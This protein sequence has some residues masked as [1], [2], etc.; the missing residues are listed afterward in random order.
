MNGHTEQ[1]MTEMLYPIAGTTNTV[2][3][4]ALLARHPEIDNVIIGAHSYYSDFDDPLAFFQRNL[5]YNFGFSGARLIL[6]KFCQLAHG[7]TFLF[8]DANH[9]SAGIS[10]YPFAVL[11]EAWAATLPLADYPFPTKGDTV[12]GSDVWFGYESLILPGVTIGHGAIIAARSV[13]TRD[14]PPYAIVAGNPARIIRLRFDP[15]RISEL[16]DM[17]WWDWPDAKIQDRLRELVL[18]LE[19]DRRSLT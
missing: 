5:R 8:P 19:Q 15:I 4:P 12:V 18:P 2:S 7:T 10:T 6:G 17:A 14:V 3:L 9:A 16:L 13:V 11:G 1:R